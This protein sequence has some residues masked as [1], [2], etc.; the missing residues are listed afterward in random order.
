LQNYQK[1]LIKKP[2]KKERIQI[3]NR[4]PLKESERLITFGNNVLP[5]KQIMTGTD[6][7]EVI[8]SA[9]YHFYSAYVRN[10]LLFWRD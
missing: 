6:I 4:H 7:T 8:G 1:N 9:A 5:V 10:K 2:T 3:D